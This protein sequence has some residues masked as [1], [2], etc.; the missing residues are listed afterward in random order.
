MT[1]SI[2]NE[3][4]GV[5]NRIDFKVFE[6]FNSQNEYMGYLIHSMNVN[7][8]AILHI[9]AK[10]QNYFATEKIKMYFFENVFLDETLQVE[11]AKKKAQLEYAE[12]MS[13]I[14]IGSCM[15]HYKKTLK[16]DSIRRKKLAD[17]YE[18][19]FLEML[20]KKNN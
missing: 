16:P 6:Q 17:E 12:T 13:N 7:M 3:L 11:V 20:S 15:V 10:T 1:I 5:I 14:C 8:D 2:K 19:N 18:K 4:T 9:K